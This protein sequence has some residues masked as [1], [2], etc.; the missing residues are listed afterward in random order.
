MWY[1]NPAWRPV[2]ERTLAERGLDDED[3][4]DAAAEFARAYG[5]GPARPP[6]RR[7]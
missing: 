6:V 4:E 7:D 3:D 2:V 1:V 5:C